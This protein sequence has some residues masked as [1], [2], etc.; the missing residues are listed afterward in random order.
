VL[1]LLMETAA[2]TGAGLLIAT[3]DNR[4]RGRF[5]RELALTAPREGS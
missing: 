4:L 5:D 2:E 3:H 1:E